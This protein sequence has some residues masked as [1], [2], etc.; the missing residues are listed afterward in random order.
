MLVVGCLLLGG[1]SCT[2]VGAK[3]PRNVS[4]DASTQPAMNTASAAHAAGSANAANIA[5]N[6]LPAIALHLA[7]DSTVSDY[8]PTTTQEG[9]GQEI[10]QFFTDKV[11]IDNQAIGGASIRTFQTGRWKNIMQALRPG[12][13]VMIQFGA[14]D[15]GTVGGRHVE[16]ADFAVALT[17][18]AD[19]ITAKGATPIFV[20]PS[21]FYQW[22]RDGKQDNA[23][24][25]PYAQAMHT[26]GAAK[27]VSVVDLNARGAEYLNSIGQA[28]ATPLYF[29]S[30][31]TVDKAH[32][33]KAG[34]T[35]M[36]ELVVGEL[37][38]IKS[39]LAAYLK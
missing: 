17:E 6:T 21:A 38:R 1:F 32:F 19:E 35:K 31:G 13:Y 18:M 27:N 34:S 24:L 15:S 7:G 28:A 3:S 9:W 16:P 2:S 37:R 11:T 20:T 8:P 33:L 26:V 12:D 29:P 39:P 10:G 22:T 5:S 4:A 36:A 25:A 23:R 30:R 14:N